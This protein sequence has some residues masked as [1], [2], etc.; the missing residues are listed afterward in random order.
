M[1]FALVTVPTPSGVWAVCADAGAVKVSCRT[2]VHGPKPH[3]VVQLSLASPLQAS[4]TKRWAGQAVRRAPADDTHRAIGF[5][6]PLVCPV[7]SERWQ[8]GRLC[9]LSSTPHAERACALMTVRTHSAR[10][11]M[12]PG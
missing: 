2:G 12:P 4:N 11:L 10:R 9:L 7:A 1:S 8:Q 3:G 6:E 5:M